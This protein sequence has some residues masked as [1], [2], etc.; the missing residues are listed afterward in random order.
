[1]E[2]KIKITATDAKEFEAIEIML[3]VLTKSVSSQIDIAQLGF[4]GLD[5]IIEHKYGQTRDLR[6]P[7]C[8]TQIAHFDDYIGVYASPYFFKIK[9]F[10]ETD[11]VNF[12]FEKKDD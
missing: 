9:M 3:S 10:K 1:M 12:I 11:T 7:S 2:H 8:V 6:L 5:C 4:L